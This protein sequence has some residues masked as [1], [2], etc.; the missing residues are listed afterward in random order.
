MRIQIRKDKWEDQRLEEDSAKVMKEDERLTSCPWSLM[1]RL[2]AR[3]SE[4][5]EPA[6]PPQVQVSSLL[7]G[8]KLQAW[9]GMRVL[10]GAWYR[11]SVTQAASSTVTHCSS[12]ACPVTPRV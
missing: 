2:S 9:P 6:R 12:M 5:L 11:D 10:R 1:K 3:A 4:L 7:Y 8:W